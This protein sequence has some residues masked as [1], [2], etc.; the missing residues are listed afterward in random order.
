LL[1]DSMPELFYI[2]LIPLTGLAATLAATPVVIR[3]AGRYNAYDTVNE[4]KV[5]RRPVSRLGGIALFCGFS[6]SF[7]VLSVLTMSDRISLDFDPSLLTAF[8]AGAALYFGLGL[9]DDF[10]EL[11]PKVKFASMVVI[12]LLVA[13]MGIK[14]GTLFGTLVL[15]AWV[16]VGFTVFWL[17]GVVNTIN[18]IDGLDGLASGISLFAAIAFLVISV[19]RTDW[20]S[21]LLLL[22]LL[23]ALIGFLP[24]NFFPAKIFLGDSGALL[25]GFILAAISVTGLYKQITVLTLAIPLAALALPIADTTFAIARRIARHVPITS[26]DR[27]H[28]HH[29]LLA[30]FCRNAYDAQSAMEGPA[31][32]SAVIACYAISLVFAG[33]A[34]YLGISG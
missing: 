34:V 23:G 9:L 20:A 11:N 22:A 6:V 8:F 33:I 3:L 25:L 32:R 19:V 14:I 10:L 4:R 7:V 30:M 15:P 2:L 26:P 12:A 16:A 13:Y 29:R 17:V 21:A 1:P 5:H 18:F 27:R 28:I 31:H 24:Y